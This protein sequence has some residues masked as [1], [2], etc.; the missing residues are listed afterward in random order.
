MNRELLLITIFLYI[1][2][3]YKEKLRAECQRFS[4]NCNPE[5]TDEEAITIFLFGITQKHFE[6][7][8]V[9]HY[10]CNHLRERF[11]KLPS[12]TAFVQRLNR[13]ESLF[14]ALFGSIT[15]DFAVSSPEILQGIRLIDSFPIILASSKR[16]SSAKVAYGFADKGYCSSKGIYCYGVKLHVSAIGRPGTLPLPEC[17]DVT[18]ANGHDLNFLREISPHLHGCKIYADKAYIDEIE[19]QMLKENNSE[20]R[21]PVKKKGQKTLSLFEQIFSAGVS[22]V[23]QPIESFFNRP[24][25]KTKIQIASKVRSYNGLMVHIFGRLSAAMFILTFNS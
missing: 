4:N 2:E 19:R 6:I 17:T 23:R 25:Q 12:Y 24:E 15:E 21:T 18:P 8:D 9:Y 10:T 1:S 11:P 16:S 22:R 14:P 7:K 20:I 13:F 5:F 3:Q